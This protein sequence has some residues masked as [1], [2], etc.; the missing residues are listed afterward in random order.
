MAAEANYNSLE[1]DK[2]LCHQLLFR[3][4]LKNFWKRSIN[5]SSRCLA[6]KNKYFCGS[7]SV[8]SQAKLIVRRHFGQS[9]ER[10]ENQGILSL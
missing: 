8:Y 2:A 9:S 10:K 7:I 3:I 5:A 1:D 4:Q 6:V